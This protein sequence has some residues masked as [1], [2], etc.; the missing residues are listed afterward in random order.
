MLNISSYLH[1]AVICLRERI[2]NA[3]LQIFFEILTFDRQDNNMKIIIREGKNLSKFLV[4]AIYLFW[5]HVQLFI[6]SV[7]RLI[8]GGT[9]KHE[10]VM[11]FKHWIVFNGTT[12]YL[13]ESSGIHIYLRFVGDVYVSLTAQ[14]AT[15]DWV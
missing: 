15:A 3:K 4:T 2:W 10:E 12:T 9:E 1:W 6:N 13:M 7:L 11:K 8:E 5:Q 14:F